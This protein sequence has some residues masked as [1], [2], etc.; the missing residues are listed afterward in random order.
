VD[1]ARTQAGVVL[2]PAR[3][4]AGRHTIR[5]SALHGEEGFNTFSKRKGVFAQSR[6]NG[7]WLLKPPFGRRVEKILE[8][9]LK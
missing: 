3:S 7:L 8:L 6:F 4:R 9:M 5:S 2:V 1:A